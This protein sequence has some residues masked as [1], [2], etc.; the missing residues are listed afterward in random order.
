MTDTRLGYGL[1]VTDLPGEQERKREP[2]PDQLR[3]LNNTQA[4]GYAMPESER[5]KLKANQAAA[6][7]EHVAALTQALKR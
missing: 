6:M 2:C 5:L 1:N 3:H 7:A 4:T